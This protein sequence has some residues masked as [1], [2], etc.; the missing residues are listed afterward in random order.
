MLN[1]L[2]KILFKCLFNQNHEEK[3][4][5]NAICQGLLWF[6]GLETS[7][8]LS[9]SVERSLRLL[10]CDH[11]NLAMRILEI[12]VKASVKWNISTALSP[13]QIQIASWNVVE[14]WMNVFKVNNTMY[15]RHVFHRRPLFI[16]NLLFKIVHV[17][18]IV[19]TVV[20]IVQIQFVFVVK[21]RRLKIRITSRPARRGK[22]STW[23]SAS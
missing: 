19:Q 20:L 10:T 14:P 8:D 7:E 9:V 12:S 5:I 18:S 3:N 2:D 15:M 4:I 22:V 21:I 1:T 11:S 23:V 13:A 17:I 16:R 6:P